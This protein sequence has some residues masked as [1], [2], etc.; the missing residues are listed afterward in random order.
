MVR[1]VANMQYLAGWHTHPVC[2]ALED[3]GIG[4][5]AAHVARADAGGKEV[6]QAN[7]RDIG[8]AVREGHQRIP[9]AQ[10]FKRRQGVFK[11][12]HALALGQ[13]HFKRG[14]GQVRIVASLQQRQADG[15]LAQ[16]AH[17]VHAAG[18]R[19]RCLG[20]QGQPRLRLGTQR[21]RG[22]RVQAQPILQSSFGARNG[23]PHR[24]ERVVKVQT[25]NADSGKIERHGRRAKKDAVQQGFAH[26]NTA[27]LRGPEWWLACRTP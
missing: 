8:V 10:E 15:L 1:I 20:A 12:V 27:A 4:F 17:V 14:A 9:V 5:G 19:P 26:Q 13:K 18:Q 7:A 2:G 16:R 3:A 24:P 21:M 6:L 23:G 25:D 11:Q 22:R